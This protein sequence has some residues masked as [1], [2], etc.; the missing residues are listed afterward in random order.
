MGDW[1]RPSS[2]QPRP[3]SW[4]PWSDRSRRPPRIP[5][6]SR[7]CSVISQPPTNENHASLDEKIA[8]HFGPVAFPKGVGGGIGLRDGRN[9]PTYVEE[10]LVGRFSGGTGRVD[11]EGRAKMFTFVRDHLPG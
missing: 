8:H 6:S 4:P 2:R 11:E 7:R 10:W 9:V 1:A 3:I 5:T